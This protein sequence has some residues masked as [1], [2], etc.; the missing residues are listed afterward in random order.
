[1]EIPLANSFSVSQKVMSPH[2]DIA[3][4]SGGGVFRL[5]EAKSGNQIIGRL[6]LGGIIYFGSAGF[7]IVNAHPLS[8][9]KPKGEFLT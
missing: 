5:V 7:E 8:A 6:E 1:M 9:V 3:G 2:V 4:A